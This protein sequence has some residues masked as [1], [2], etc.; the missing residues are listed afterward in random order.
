[1]CIHCGSSLSICRGLRRTKQLGVRQ[2]RQ[3]KKC[4]RKFT[5]RHQRLSNK[6]ATAAETYVEQKSENGEEACTPETTAT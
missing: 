4:G 1:M 2:I 5:P 6:P 3:C